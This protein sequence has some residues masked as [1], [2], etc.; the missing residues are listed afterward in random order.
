MFV[1]D[2]A[3]EEKRDLVRD[4]PPLELGLLL[5][6]RDAGLEVGRLEIGDTPQVNLET[7]RSSI[8]VISFGGRRS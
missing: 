5:H 6:D 1:F 2:V 3:R 8:A 4:V 7:N